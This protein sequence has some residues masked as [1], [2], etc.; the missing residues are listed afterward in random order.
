[1]YFRNTKLASIPI[2]SSEQYSCGHHPEGVFLSMGSSSESITTSHMPFMRTSS[3]WTQHGSS[4]N[5]HHQYPPKTCTLCLECAL[6]FI[7][8]ETQL[9]LRRVK[10]LQIVRLALEK[11]PQQ[12]TTRSSSVMMTTNSK[13][14]GTSQPYKGYSQENSNGSE[15]WLNN[16]AS[17]SSVLLSWILRML[18][19]N[20]N[21][22]NSGTLMD[23]TP[24]WTLQSGFNKGDPEP[25]QHKNVDQE[26]LSEVID[27]FFQHSSH[28]FVLNNLPQIT[29]M[30]TFQHKSDHVLES[31]W[32][33]FVC[34]LFT[35]LHG[36]H[37]E[38][39]QKVMTV[40]KFMECLNVMLALCINYFTDGNMDT[41]SLTQ[42]TLEKKTTSLFI[43]TKYLQLDM[44]KLSLGSFES[45]EFV[46]SLLNCLLK[47]D[48]EDMH[49]NALAVLYGLIE[50]CS[51][52]HALN[53][54]YP[55]VS[56]LS[57]RT[58]TLID[59]LISVILSPNI[60]IQLLTAKIILLLC[61]IGSTTNENPQ[62]SLNHFT[63]SFMNS[64]ICDFIFE[65]LRKSQSSLLSETLL[66]I[67]CCFVEYQS[68]ELD[69][70]WISKA[71][72]QKIILLGIDTFTIYF[73]P[74]CTFTNDMDEHSLCIMHSILKITKRCFLSSESFV[75]HQELEQSCSSQ[76][77]TK[78]ISQCTFC[79]TSMLSVLKNEQQQVI[80]HIISQETTI[81]LM[82]TLN[83]YLKY[84][85]VD[86]PQQKS[87]QIDINPFFSKMLE[88]FKILM[89]KAEFDTTHEEFLLQF[90]SMC[91]IGYENVS[92]QAFSDK[93]ESILLNCF[94]VTMFM[95]LQSTMSS[96]FSACIR[97]IISRLQTQHSNN[98]AL[99]K[100]LMEKK[101]LSLLFQCSSSDMQLVQ[102]FKVLALQI[103]YTL[104]LC[105]RNSIELESFVQDIGL[106]FEYLRNIMTCR[107]RTQSSND[108]FLVILECII[109]LMHASFFNGEQPIEHKQAHSLL[110]IFAENAPSCQGISLLCKLKYCEL[111]AYL[112][113]EYDMRSSSAHAQLIV[114]WYLQVASSNLPKV[115]VTNAACIV[116]WLA[117][118]HEMALPGVT[119][120]FISNV[121]L[122]GNAR[123][124]SGISL[125]REAGLDVFQALIQMVSSDKQFNHQNHSMQYLC[126]FH[127]YF[128]K[129]LHISEREITILL[130]HIVE[131]ILC[132]CYIS[133]KKESETTEICRL[134][135][136]ISILLPTLLTRADLN[137][138]FS[139][140]LNTQ[141]ISL[142]QME[143]KLFQAVSLR[144]DDLW[145]C[146]IPV[147]NMISFLLFLFAR[148]RNSNSSNSISFHITN[149]LSK[150]VVCVEN[151]IQR[152]DLCGDTS[153]TQTLTERKTMHDTKI[154][155]FILQLQTCIFM[156]MKSASNVNVKIL[157]HVRL[158][159]I[160]GL[161]HHSPLIRL[162]ASTALCTICSKLEYEEKCQVWKY[163]LVY[164]LLN[165]IVNQNE[166]TVALNSVSTLYM[167]ECSRPKSKSVLSQV[168][169]NEFIVRSVIGDQLSIATAEGSNC[170]YNP[171]FIIYLNYLYMMS[172]TPQQFFSML[173]PFLGNEKF[174]QQLLN[175]VEISCVTEWLSLIK[176]LLGT[177]S[178]LKNE[179]KFKMRAQFE[180]ILCD[181]EDHD[182]IEMMKMSF[183]PS[184]T[185][186][187]GN[188]NIGHSSTQHSQ[189]EQLSQ[190]NM[191]LPFLSIF[192]T[193]LFVIGEIIF[194]PN[195]SNP[196]TTEYIVK[197][198]KDAKC[199]VM[200]QQQ[201]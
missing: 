51:F 108:H 107:S 145:P 89:S 136:K 132:N 31:S 6:K 92:L 77:F 58:D 189:Y 19:S 192:T 7:F 172:P 84:F 36:V 60:D 173:G 143:L 176:I 39:I 28:D 161:N 156:T 22:S 80:P 43:M 200:H 140:A 57:D 85:L 114:S 111:F 15:V 138:P 52:P 24:V 154:L 193:E 103:L 162:M 120:A 25:A 69:E 185:P 105:E 23:T 98:T 133:L 137:V 62:A 37:Q 4:F 21:N 95:S 147:G 13:S 5:H 167:L 53:E 86:F 76:L 54:K 124:I 134:C 10:A 74:S 190:R 3:S 99:A 81:S 14:F 79:A 93:M 32:L 9:S 1:M 175:S 75:M 171:S 65:C 47:H 151:I 102:N 164:S 135:E 49:M 61:N 45:V 125:L 174:L 180:R 166:E 90:L 63:T 183:L 121:I 146:S 59:S 123:S 194:N 42:T 41:S 73:S 188:D 198:C 168:M 29:Q 70:S 35:A 195:L 128:T 96:V 129:E 126:L 165:N 115:E 16:I 142:F 131:P 94:S 187:H 170:K 149:N 18:D 197:M 2:G 82:K 27:L 40:E 155:A 67:L 50:K 88:I 91:L 148:E 144:E 150:V 152:L 196:N 118:H 163:S 8:D 191:T 112:C 87:D 182:N 38:T 116:R 78:I 179:L 139:T 44:Q 130:Q 97:Y 17:M 83:E 20:I 106:D 56:V 12:P 100:Q 26:L 117:R 201:D 158:I 186:K 177:S 181:L 64:D 33:H 127:E 34:G 119:L 157:L 159:E 30:L 101:V 178:P 199:F 72:I 46:T 169:W 109:V 68:L 71:F 113:T 110:T 66:S 160:H 153:Q 122:A 141:L 11:L 48:S 184:N 55:L 104:R